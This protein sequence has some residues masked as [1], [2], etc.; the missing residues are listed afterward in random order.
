[1]VAVY[2]TKGQS[3]PSWKVSHMNE[4]ESVTSAP[5]RSVRHT[6]THKCDPRSR[7]Y[8]THFALTSSHLYARSV[9]VLGDVARQAIDGMAR[10]RPTRLCSPPPSVPCSRSRRGCCA[11]LPAL[12]RWRTAPPLAI[13]LS[14]QSSAW[15]QGPIGSRRTA[16]TPRRV[17]TAGSTQSIRWLRAI[18]ADWL[19]VAR[20]QC[21]R[22]RRHRHRRDSPPAAAADVGDQGR[23]DRP[24]GGGRPPG[25]KGRKRWILLKFHFPS[26]PPSR[27]LSFGRKLQCSLNRHFIYVKLFYLKTG[28]YPV[29]ATSAEA[30]FAASLSNCP[31][32]LPARPL[33]CP[34]CPPAPAGP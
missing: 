6:L 17:S 31:A 32:V 26:I 2:Q 12:S 7:Q 15:R 19:A 23:I 16:T 33:A 24:A 9:G 14:S 27:I 25:H 28:S 34:G 10:R 4:A 18:K 1:M 21:A 11:L 22:G 30:S 20:L 13:P 3:S 29:R 8:F 5:K